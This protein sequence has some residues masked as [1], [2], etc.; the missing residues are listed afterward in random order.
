MNKLLIIL[1]IV[2][3]SGS[4][5][6][7]ADLKSNKSVQC[8]LETDSCVAKMAIRGDIHIETI[9]AAYDPASPGS[10]DTRGGQG[11]SSGGSR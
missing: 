10:P 1:G 5:A 7:S 6:L 11:G 8:S 4:D 9:L 2:L 3:L